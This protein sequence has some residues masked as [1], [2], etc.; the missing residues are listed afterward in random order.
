M[1]IAFAPEVELAVTEINDRFVQ[2][3]QGGTYPGHGEDGPEYA[4]DFWSTDKAVHDRVLA[5]VIYSADRLGVKYII[6][7]ERIWSVARQDE[8]IR[9][10]RRDANRDG[11]LSASERHTNHIH[12]SFDPS[13]GYMPSAKEIA[14]ELAVNTKFLNAVADAVA[15]RDGNVVNNFTDNAANTHV[16]IATALGVLGERTKP[17]V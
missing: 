10:Y 2:L 12:I 16:S 14:D 15:K 11:M 8:G 5:W 3:G 4:A 1:A 9:P 7:W 17:G 13:G 6:S